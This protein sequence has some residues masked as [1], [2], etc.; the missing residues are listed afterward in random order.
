MNK[1]MER[2][3]GITQEYLRALFTYRDDGLL[4][5]NVRTDLE[6]RQ[7]KI[8]NKR[9]AGRVASPNP[10]KSGYRRVKINGRKYSL[11][12]IIWIFFNG[13]I[14]DGFF[15]DHTN[16]NPQ[17]NRIENIRL[18]RREENARNS[19]RVANKNGYAGV[20][21]GEKHRRFQARISK[22]GKRLN[23]GMFDTA[24]E[25]HQAYSAASVELHGNFSP[26]SKD[27]VAHG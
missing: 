6:G 25:A 19:T 8:W 1:S 21:R 26:Y 2:D 23:L 7:I 16:R 9:Y 3:L 24:T 5:W 11:H 27:G 17:D 20:S 12:R 4:V 14:P 22:D 18:A 13:D 10:S 15:A